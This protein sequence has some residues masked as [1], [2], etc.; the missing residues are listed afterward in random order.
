MMIWGSKRCPIVAKSLMEV[1]LT[2][3][4][5]ILLLGGR[6]YPPDYPT[7]ANLG[8]H[9]SMAKKRCFL[10]DFGVKM[11]G[12]EGGWV[13]YW[14]KGILGVLYPQSEALETAKITPDPQLRGREGESGGLGLHRV[15]ERESES[16]ERGRY[17]EK[18][19]E[20]EGSPWLLHL[21][22]AFLLLHL[23][24]HG[25]FLRENERNESLGEKRGF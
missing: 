3:H 4:H 20:G 18:E 16:G 14:M 9:C 6:G 22:H 11:H 25:L 5:P 2:Y 12:K 8:L 24:F 13:R 1:A 15:W 10:R 19:R 21:L 17:L 7:Q 23:G